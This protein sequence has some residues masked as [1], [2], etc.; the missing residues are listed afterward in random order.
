MHISKAIKIETPTVEVDNISRGWG[1]GATPI[2]KR[3]DLHVCWVS[4]NGP[5]LNDTFSC[6]KIPILKIGPI[7]YSNHIQLLC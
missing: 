7:L 3:P 2:Y 6:K 4:E 5:I 1:G